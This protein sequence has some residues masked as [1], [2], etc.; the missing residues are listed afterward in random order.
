MNP[1]I[2]FMDQAKFVWEKGGTLMPGLGLL[3]LY[4]YYLSFDLWL[5][6]KGGHPR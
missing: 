5:T 4:L 1:V 3:A 6:F 2:E